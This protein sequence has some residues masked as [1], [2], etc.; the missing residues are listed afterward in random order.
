M[1]PQVSA[2]ANKSSGH[3]HITVSPIVL[4]VTVNSFVFLQKITVFTHPYK[5]FSNVR[6]QELC[7]SNKW[8]GFHVYQLAKSVATQKPSCNRLFV[9][10][11]GAT[12]NVSNSQS[13]DFCKYFAKRPCLKAVLQKYLCHVG[14]HGR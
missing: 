10:K 9:Q 12:R 1:S 5:I 7:V 6:I 13:F 14:K 8:F 2:A 11:L 3:R 4:R